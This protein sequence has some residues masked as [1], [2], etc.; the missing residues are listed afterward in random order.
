MSAPTAPAEDGRTRVHLVWLE[1]RVEHWIRFGAVVEETLIDRRRRV[2]AF[3]AGAIFAFV[4]WASNDF[5]TVVSRLDIVRAA[6]PGQ[7]YSTLP[8]V[9]PGGEI[10]LRQSGWPRVQQVLQTIDAVEALG[11]A[12]AAAA[13]DHWRH[14]HNRLAAGQAPRPYTRNRHRA[15]LLRLRTGT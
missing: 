10:L 6:A 4:R 5:G 8:H 12:P 7:A 13:P 9:R 1:G 3:E 11:I 2:V 15:W 14:L